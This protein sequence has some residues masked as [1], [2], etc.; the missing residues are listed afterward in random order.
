MPYVD[1]KGEKR[2]TGIEERKNKITIFTI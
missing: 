1:P 2:V